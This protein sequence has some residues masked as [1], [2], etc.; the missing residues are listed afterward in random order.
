MRSDLLFP[1]RLPRFLVILPLLL[2]TTL[3]QAEEP[4]NVLFPSLTPALATDIVTGK[5]ALAAFSRQLLTGTDT[6]RFLVN[7]ATL[8]PA[9]KSAP[10]KVRVDDCAAFFSLLRNAAPPNRVGA[11]AFPLEREPGRLFLGEQVLVD[12]ARHWCQGGL[13][14]LVQPESKC[15][16]GGSCAN[17]FVRFHVELLS[18]VGP[19]VSWRTHTSTASAGAPP[20]QNVDW[21]TWNLSTRAPAKLADVLEEASL[22]EALGKH[23]WVQKTLGKDFLPT[24]ATSDE[25]FA[26]LQDHTE[27][28]NDFT[29]FTFA[30]YN[31]KKG[32]ATVQLAYHQGICKLCPNDVTM[33]SLQVAVKNEHRESFQSSEKGPGFFLENEKAPRSL[34]QGWVQPKK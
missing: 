31:A 24:L 19:F 5:L 15:L 23:P 28:K 13:D 12:D 29:R 17:D 22:R 16:K 14:P 10:I 26:A 21:V 25:V 20:T 7:V 30:G 33:L 18:L 1:P 4:S 9:D 3:A 27:G 34:Y 6:L 11:D 8:E 32:I 2:T